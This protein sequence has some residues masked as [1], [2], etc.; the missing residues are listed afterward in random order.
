MKLWSGNQAA[1]ICTMVRTAC[2][3]CRWGGAVWTACTVHTY[4]AT[5]GDGERSSRTRRSP[6]C[7]VGNVMSRHVVLVILLYVWAIQLLTYF[8]PANHHDVSARQALHRIDCKRTSASE[9]WTWCISSCVAGRASDS[10]C[11]TLVRDTVRCHCA[12]G[13]GLPGARRA[14]PARGLAVRR[15]RTRRTL[16]SFRNTNICLS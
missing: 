6:P 1:S 16:V 15:C 9:G 3:G 5:P 2:A 7:Q 12:G 11:V 8:E 4:A 14:P 13:P 10:E